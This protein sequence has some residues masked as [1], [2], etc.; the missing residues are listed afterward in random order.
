MRSD[1][2]TPS[3]SSAAASAGRQSCSIAPRSTA[4]SVKVAG[5][6]VERALDDGGGVAVARAQ[7]DLVGDDHA[8]QQ[9]TGGLLIGRDGR[10][11]LIKA[12]R[13]EHGVVVDSG[14]DGALQGAF[15]R[16]PAQSVAAVVGTRGI[17]VERVGE[18]RGQV[19]GLVRGQIQQQGV[20][21]DRQGDTVG[22]EVGERAARP[23]RGGKDRLSREVGIERHAQRFEGA[24]AFHG[25][26]N[27]RAADAALVGAQIQPRALHARGSEEIEAQ[28]VVVVADVPSVDAG[29]GEMEAEITG[30]R[31]H[32]ERIGE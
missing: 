25:G 32:E 3:A 27:P 29:R 30:R 28:A 6:A 14:R 1:T 19:Q 18:V 20:A 31:I 10:A 17:R 22:R 16:R 12:G 23:G 13:G 7:R 11:L 8:V 21:A 9:V 4:A 26:G 5:A 24:A 2:V 15:G